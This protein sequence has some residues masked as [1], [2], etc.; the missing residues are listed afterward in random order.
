MRS[1]SLLRVALVP[2]WVAVLLGVGAAHVTAQTVLQTFPLQHIN[3]KFETIGDVDGDGVRDLGF[4]RWGGSLDVY[5]VRSG[6]LLHQF[7]PPPQHYWAH[8]SFVRMGDVDADGFD[9]LSYWELRPVGSGWVAFSVI[10]SGATGAYL[11]Q[12]QW[13]GG[14]PAVGLDDLNGDGHDDFLLWHSTANVGALTLAGHTDILDGATGQVIRSHSGTGSGQE[15]MVAWPLGDLDGDGVRD[16]LGR[17]EGMFASN[18]MTRVFSGATGALIST[19]PR[20]GLYLRDIGDFD[21]DGYDDMILS[22]H[23][24]YAFYYTGVYA[25]PGLTQVLWYNYQVYGAP[26][27][28]AYVV[29]GGHH[30]DFDGDG[31][32]D[33]QLAG[34]MVG[35][36]VTL[37][38]GRDGS[39]LDAIPVSAIPNG[40]LSPGALDGPGDANGDG[41]P[42]HWIIDDIVWGVTR[43]LRLLSGAPP[44]VL[45]FG[46]GCPDQTGTTPTM[47]IGVGAKLGKTLTVNLSNA[48][49][50]HVGAF[51]GLGFSATTWLGVA[52]PFD[53]GLVGMPGCDWYVAA[54]APLAVATIGPPGGRH[55]ATVPIMVPA[56][57]GLLGAEVF[58]QWLVLEVGPS[59]PTGSTTRAMR[60]TVVP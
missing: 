38:A 28:P 35:D 55:R 53:L 59:G 20:F 22:A 30:G 17:D 3:D 42:D 21:A 43:V 54:D 44:G 19:Y 39:I 46:T 32:A 58:G 27:P 36:R 24:Q 49:P 8:R 16:Y 34:G 40:Q 37:L 41:F 11:H 48:N 33:L 50:N 23:A 13:D 25:G 31:H 45:L 26:I 1:P 47:G 12:I 15:F 4:A 10:R 2:A 60:T 52:L 57:N 6:T 18:P 7:V 9:D 5:S 29:H 51:L 56:N 14:M